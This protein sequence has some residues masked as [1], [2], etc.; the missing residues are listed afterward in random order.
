MPDNDPKLMTVFAEAL[1][2]TDPAERAAYLDVACED[3]AALRRRVEALLAAHDGAGRFL[4]PDSS[5]TS[6]A[7][8]PETEGAARTTVPETDSS[9]Q[10][11]T[12]EHRANGTPTTAGPAPADRPGGFVP[13]QVIAGRYTLLDVSARA[14]WA[15]STGP[16]RPSRSSG[17]WR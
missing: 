10:Q 9:L 14:G 6:D 15:P 12:S 17:R 13:G 1:E 2:R 5:S 11:A 7:A 3:D 16:A 8:G 4:E